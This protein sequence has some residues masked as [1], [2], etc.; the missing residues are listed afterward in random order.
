[1]KI[2]GYFFLISLLSVGSLYAQ[3]ADKAKNLVSEGVVLEDNGK[4]EEALTKYQQALDADKDNATALAEMALSLLSLHRYEDAIKYCKTAIKTHPG[5][6][7][8]E[9]VYVTYGTAYD[10]LRKS[11][12]AIDIYNEGIKAFPDYYSLYYNKGITLTMMSK[13]E[14]SLVCFEK[15]VTLKPDHPGS[16]FAI[17]TVCST[18]HQTI[19]AIMGYFRLISIEPQTNRAKQALT[20]IQY[21]LSKNV[22]KKGDNNV[23]IMVNPDLLDVAN[24]KKVSNNFSAT[25]LNVTMAAGLD[26]DSASKNLSPAQNFKRKLDILCESLKETSKYNSGFF[27]TYYAPYFIEM[28]DK[29]MTT[30]FSYLALTTSGNADVT[31]WLAQHKTETDAFTKWSAGFEWK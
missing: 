16:H 10:D 23:T 7:A 30:V 6:K 17:G 12:K 31:D 1:M 4:S 19:P 5:N 29:D 9:S 22:E 8:L 21:L 13:M 15:S 18:L 3:D 20:N 11:G 25:E 14:E 27:W 24:K 28:K 2:A 26:Y